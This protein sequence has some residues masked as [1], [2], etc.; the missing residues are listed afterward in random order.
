[1]NLCELHNAC[2]SCMN[3][4]CCNLHLGC[5]MI[6][7]FSVW[8]S[9]DYYPVCARAT[10]GGKLRRTSKEILMKL[11]RGIFFPFS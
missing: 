6:L 2:W 5:I 11:R 8:N 7:F 10:T 1:M 3:S 9:Q 4:C